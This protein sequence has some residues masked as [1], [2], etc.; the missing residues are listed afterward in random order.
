VPVKPDPVITAINRYRAASAELDKLAVRGPM[1][2]NGNPA[3]ETEEYAST[4]ARAL[5]FSLVLERLD[6]FRTRTDPPA[7]RHLDIPETR[8]PFDPE[9]AKRALPETK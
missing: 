7:A 2:P 8:L 6:C 9:F 1:L 5:L 3:D 4:P